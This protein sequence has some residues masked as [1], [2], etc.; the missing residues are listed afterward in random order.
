M[1]TIW[2]GLA[3][4]GLAACA[5][6]PAPE[7]PALVLEQACPATGAVG[8]PFEHVIVLANR[9]SEATG[10]LVLTS[11]VAGGLGYETSDPAA[12]VSANNLTWRLGPLAPGATRRFVVRL[13]AMQRGTLESVATV[14]DSGGPTLRLLAPVAF[15]SPTLSLRLGGPPAAGADEAVEFTVSLANTGDGDAGGVRVAAAL[16]AGLVTADATSWNAG[17][18]AP[19]ATRSFRV[20]ARAG[21]AGR[22]EVVA[23][24][25]AEGG[26]SARDTLTTTVAR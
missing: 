19:G 9:G 20:A 23:T 1:R 3:A 2:T 17:T 18:L 12:E 21:Q 8:R 14:T 15:T 4:L 22:W 26:F 11:Q 5:S 16:P 10:E 7:G 6:E 13:H 25:T 24:A